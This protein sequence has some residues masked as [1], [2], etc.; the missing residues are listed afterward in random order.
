MSYQADLP[1]N[2]KLIFIH[3]PKCAGMSVRAWY[4]KNIP[5]NLIIDNHR[6]YT[7]FNNVDNK[8]TWTIVRNPYAR[9]MSWYRFRGH[10]LKKRRRKH[11][12]Y[13]IEKP[14]WEKGFNEWIQYY[15]DVDWFDHI[16]G[17]QMHGPEPNGYFKLSTPQVKWL[18]D[19][20]GE[21]KID[22]ILK[23]EN[24]KEDFKIIQ[25]ITGVNDNLGTINNTVKD[26][27][28]NFFLNK[29]SIKLIQE[30]YKDDF[31]ILGY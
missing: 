6:P 5:N 9:A 17:N 12:V 23:I 10:I 2:K 3:I 4:K 7:H 14:I 24:L 25:D 16:R 8:I 1:N 27:N 26:S 19:D 18:K 21:I 13:N 15:F 31:E 30:W 28:E 29:N 22:H 20:D 11:P